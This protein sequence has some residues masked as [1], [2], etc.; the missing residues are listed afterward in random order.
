MDTTSRQRTQASSLRTMAAFIKFRVNIFIEAKSR[1]NNIHL[2][3]VQ[4][5]PSNKYICKFFHY[6]KKCN[7]DPA[8]KYT[9]HYVWIQNY[10]FNMDFNSM[11]DQNQQDISPFN[12]QP[13]LVFL[14]PYALKRVKFYLLKKRQDLKVKTCLC[15]F[16]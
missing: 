3:Y 7:N 2:Q 14:T 5:L 6:C 13:Y 15:L 4:H 12:Y 10:E 16:L 1:G 9:K 11:H 8:K